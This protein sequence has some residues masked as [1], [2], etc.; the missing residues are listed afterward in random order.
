MGEFDP[1]SAVVSLDS[2]VSQFLDARTGRAGASLEPVGSPAFSAFSTYLHETVHWWQHI[3]TTAGLL[4]G[5]SIPVQALATTLYLSESG[6]S[7]SK[8]LTDAISHS[9]ASDHP[10]VLAVSRWSEIELAAGLLYS[11]SNANARLEANPRFYESLGHSLLLA[12]ISTVAGLARTLDPQCL[13]LPNAV[14]WIPYYEDFVKSQRQYFVPNQLVQLPLGMREILEGQARFA[15]LQYRSLSYRDARRQAWLGGV[16]T[17]AFD[18]Y[19]KIAGLPVPDGFNDASV[20]LFL[21]LCDIALNPSSGYPDPIDPS[22]DSVRDLHPG[23]R[24]LRL[25]GEVERDRTIVREVEK[26]GYKSYVNASRRLCERLDWLDPVTVG[27]HCLARGAK[28]SGW[29]ELQQQFEMCDFG[30]ED[31]PI[32]FY[33]GKHLE[34]LEIKVECPHFYC[35][36]AR[37][38]TFSDDHCHEAAPFQELLSWSMPPFVTSSLTTGVDATNLTFG[39]KARRSQFVNSYF[40]TLVLYDMVRQWISNRGAFRFDYKWKGG[41]TQTEL[42]S[43]W[44]QFEKSMGLSHTELT[45]F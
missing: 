42:E 21:L 25:C 38:L 32:R 8:P 43:I 5:L 31:V 36:P 23:I 2:G 18:E 9:Q 35:W 13:G 3:G 26:V 29:A 45:I 1:M 39:T 24:F 27:Q 37:F 28:I 6:T 20:N 40:A 14:D 41:F 7:V 16:Y 11:P 34:F 17:V 19:L 44:G 15:E 12:Q 22:R 30:S 10:A 4:Y 33:M